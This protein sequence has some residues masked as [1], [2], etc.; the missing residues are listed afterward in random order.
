MGGA[1][2]GYE[3]KREEKK[4]MD[5]MKSFQEAAT[6][7][8]IG[9]AQIGRQ[10]GEVLGF[11]K[12]SGI[13]GAARTEIGAALIGPGYHAAASRFAMVK[14]GKVV[15]EVPGSAPIVGI[16][17]I[18]T[19]PGTPATV[20][21]AIQKEISEAAPTQKSEIGGALIGPGY[22]EA[23]Q[24]YAVI[25]AG[26]V[27]EVSAQAPAEVG[28]RYMTSSLSPSERFYAR[29]P[30]ETID[31]GTPASVIETIQKSIGE[32]A[33][34]W[35]MGFAHVAGKAREGVE[36]SIAGWKWGISE[37]GG[38][39]SESFGN[40]GESFGEVTSGVGDFL[41]SFKYQ[42]LLPV[43][44]LAFIA[45]MVAIGYSGLGAPAAR[46]AEREYVK[47]R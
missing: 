27:S 41:K 6:G 43:I 46:V 10:V 16:R 14:A 19:D 28:V 24:R 30:S 15:T 17:Y 4:S 3:Y 35:R 29:I 2:G 40:V 47:R 12:E 21:A 39:V 5:I 11:S 9:A 25:K 20:V 42:A 7:L 26:G 31:P 33:E 36:K 22:A 8:T 44:I 34:G 45:V 32:S 23:Q 1:R 13:T 37:A 38:K 18:P